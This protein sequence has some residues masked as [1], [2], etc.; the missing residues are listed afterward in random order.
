MPK[1]AAL[2]DDIDALKGIVLE[3]SRAL[4]VAEAL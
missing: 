2:P 3:R 4:E 1:T